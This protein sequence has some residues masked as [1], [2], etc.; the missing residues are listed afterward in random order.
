MKEEKSKQDFA[1][2]RPLYFNI[3]L[4]LALAMALMAFEWK[5]QDVPPEV[6]FSNSTDNFR[7]EEV[8][9][10]RHEVPKP[11][12]PKPQ[13]IKV[14]EDKVEIEIEDFKLDIIDE[15][16]EP[17]GDPVI[18]DIEPEAEPDFHL[19]VEKMPKFN[20]GGQAEFLRYIGKQIRYPK[21]ARKLDVSGKVFVQFVIDKKGNISDIEVIKG[22][23]FGCD[24]EVIRVL[25]QAPKWEPGKQRGK[26]VRVKMVLP[27]TFQLGS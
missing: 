22:I 14:V 12:K 18:E 6:S 3:G 5:F 13:V 27:V 4:T 16:D 25:K 9:I 2:A 17:M 10:T 15:L 11:P 19:V 24:E 1:K 20:G 21:L 23:G 26:P 8:M 7:I